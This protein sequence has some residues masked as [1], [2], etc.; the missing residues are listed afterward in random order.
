MYEIIKSYISNRCFF[1]EQQEKFADLK[2]IIVNV[3]GKCPV[4]RFIYRLIYNY[5][6]H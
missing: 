3:S 2:P 4:P 5:Y 6:F 1:V